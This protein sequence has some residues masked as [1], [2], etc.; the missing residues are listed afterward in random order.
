MTAPTNAIRC[1]TSRSGLHLHAR[2][3]LALSAR[4]HG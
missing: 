1:P 3:G 4:W 2:V